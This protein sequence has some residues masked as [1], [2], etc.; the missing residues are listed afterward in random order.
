MA[1]TKEEEEI[2]QKASQH[3]PLTDAEK[4]FLNEYARKLV[5]KEIKPNPVGS[6]KRYSYAELM[7]MV[8]S[9]R[10]LPKKIF[11]TEQ[12]YTEWRNNGIT[13]ENIRELMAALLKQYKSKKEDREK[14]R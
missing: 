6:R 11:F 9:G 3:L 12:Q 8:A 14:E 7:D 4:E 1:R 2:L 10:T 5:A 13:S